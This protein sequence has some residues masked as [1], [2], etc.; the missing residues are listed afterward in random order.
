MHMTVEIYV[1]GAFIE[2][3]LGC[4]FPENYRT[5]ILVMKVVSNSYICIFNHGIMFMFVKINVFFKLFSKIAPQRA[6]H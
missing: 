1:G 2:P 5:N 4:V 3:K 6:S